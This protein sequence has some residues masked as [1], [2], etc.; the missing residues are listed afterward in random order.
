VI[1][2]VREPAILRD[3]DDRDRDSRDARDN[4]DD[5]DGHD[6]RDKRDDA[7]HQK[8]KPE[9]KA[10]ETPAPR[11]APIP[12]LKVR[13]D[14]RDDRKP[15]RDRPV[16]VPERG[17][18]EPGKTTRTPDFGAVRLPEPK[19]QVELPSLTVPKKA[20]MSAPSAAPGRFGNDVRTDRKVVVQPKDPAPMAAAP[21]EDGDEDDAPAAKAPK[22]KDS[23]G[24]RSRK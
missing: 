21:D 11:P 24:G 3:R 22:A 12:S 9:P 15:E 19:K 16:V 5:R 10:H 8:E 13:D 18:I 14:A 17:R 20:E 4:R 23:P 1:T 7:A 2:V 6:D